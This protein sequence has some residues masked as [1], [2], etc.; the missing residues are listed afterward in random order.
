M[1]SHAGQGAVLEAAPTPLEDL[2]NKELLSKDISGLT[3]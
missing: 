1:L 2:S 3:L